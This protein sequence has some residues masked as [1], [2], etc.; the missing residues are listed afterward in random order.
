MVKVP[1]L[2]FESGMRFGDVYE[3]LSHAERLALRAAL[4]ALQP[5]AAKWALMQLHRQMAVGTFTLF[6]RAYRSPLA[7][8]SS[9]TR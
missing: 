9:L 1:E 2:R 4:Q 3:G 7:L 8:P 5:V 6:G